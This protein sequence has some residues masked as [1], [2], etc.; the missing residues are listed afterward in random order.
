MKSKSGPD[1]QN[2]TLAQSADLKESEGLAEERTIFSGQ[3]DAEMY[4]R[5]QNLSAGA[6]L[7]AKVK[8]LAGGDHPGGAFQSGL[9]AALGTVDLEG[10]K[11]YEEKKAKL[12]DFARDHLKGKGATEDDIAATLSLPLI[13]HRISILS[14]GSKTKLLAEGI[15][16][17]HIQSEKFNAFLDNIGSA[18]GSEVHAAPLKNY[19]RMKTKEDD[20][21]GGDIGRIKDVIRASFIFEDVKQIIAAQE[22]IKGMGS[23]TV[24][25]EK[26]RF[27]VSEAEASENLNYRDVIFIVQ[28]DQITGTPVKIELQLHLRSL[29]EAKTKVK[30]SFPNVEHHNHVMKITGRL[31]LNKGKI[32]DNQYTGHDFYKVI[33]ELTKSEVQFEQEIVEAAKTESR[34]I[35]GGA[36]DEHSK[37]E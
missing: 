18:T 22:T 14:R 19:A 3:Q 28:T 31:G 7:Q 13:D 23:H 29:H 10:L 6:P 30:A 1:Q 20:K 2:E 17:Q 25:E 27:D 21:Y 24:V 34:K 32:Q 4:R 36:W 37:E 12:I 35:Y 15:E 9:N 11:G 33:R 5:V 8:Q 26:D 16:V